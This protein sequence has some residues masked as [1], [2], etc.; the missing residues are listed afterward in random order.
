MGCREAGEGVLVSTHGVTYTRLE[1]FLIRMSWMALVR[2]VRDQT[3]RKLAYGHLNIHEVS[4]EY[5]G[6]RIPMVD[7]YR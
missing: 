1:D 4:E 7:V 6:I 3:A 2:V 5:P